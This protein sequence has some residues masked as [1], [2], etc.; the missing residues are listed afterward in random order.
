MRLATA[1]NQ[2]VSEQA[3]WALVKDDPARAGTVLYVAL[4]CIDNL[5][6]LFAPFL[7][8]T[9]QALHEQLGYTDI[10]SGPLEFREV[11]DSDG[12]SHTVLTG[13]YEQWGGRWVPSRLEAGRPLAAPSP[14]FKKLDPQA[15]VEDELARME[16]AANAA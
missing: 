4:R 9:A 7:P 11:D 6:V 16:A 15:V 3:P 1:V 14:L 5:K 10:L 12:T 8:F 2:Y 13:D